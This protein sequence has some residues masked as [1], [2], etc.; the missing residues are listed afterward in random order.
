MTTW[1]DAL[2]R[3]RGTLG[4]WTASLD[5]QTPEASQGV[6]REIESLGYAALWIPEAWGREALTHAALLLAGTHELVVATGIANIWAR[7]AVS[8]TNAARTLTSFSHERFVLGL[9]VS[10]RPLVER[11]RGHDY[12]HPLAT[13]RDYLTAMDNVPMFAAEHEA[14]APR[15]LAALGPK[16]LE[17]ARD[18]GDGALTYLVTAEH[19]HTARGLLGEKFLGVELS[20]VL[21]ESR[22]EFLRRGHAHL[23]FYTGLPNYQ[24]SWRRLGFGDEDF[25]RGGS[26]RL[27]DAIVV[28][29]DAEAIESRVREHRDAGADH[30]CLQVLGEEMARVPLTQWGDLAPTREVRR[31]SNRRR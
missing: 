4:L 26:Q 14:S 11:L 13:M 10:H 31:E 16:M 24:E 28:H 1:P 30:V 29:G 9:G 2:E 6:A 22:E 5:A 17:L 3:L 25:V 27:V 19:T 23:E 8:A 21:G 20:V 12:D 15:V 7:D 18:H